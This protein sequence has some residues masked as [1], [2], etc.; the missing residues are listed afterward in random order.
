[1]AQIKGMTLKC[2]TKYKGH[3]RDRSCVNFREIK[4]QDMSQSHGVPY[5]KNCVYSPNS[6][7]MFVMLCNK[8]KSRLWTPKFGLKCPESGTG[9]QSPI[10]HQHPKVVLFMLS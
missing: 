6:R 7:P 9:V 1:M 8:S 2:T 3:V 10:I 4:G 5:K